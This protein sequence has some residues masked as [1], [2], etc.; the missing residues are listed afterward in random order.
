ME[1]DRKK[2]Q[3]VNKAKEIIYVFG[4]FLS[5]KSSNPFWKRGNKIMISNHVIKLK[6]VIKKLENIYEIV[7][8]VI[9]YLLSVFD[10]V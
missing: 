4:F 7:A 9:M 6:Y 2:L 3:I 8:I 10:F 1:N 5:S